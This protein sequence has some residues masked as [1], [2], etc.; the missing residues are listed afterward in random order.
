MA[1]LAYV[2]FMFASPPGFAI[3]TLSES[4]KSNDSVEML[5]IPG[6][7]LHYRE[8]DRAAL[9]QWKYLDRETT[10]TGFWI[11]RTEVTVEQ[12]FRC[13]N[14][15]ACQPTP[16]TTDQ[17]L[18]GQTLAPPDPE[19]GKCE[20]CL[21]YTVEPKSFRLCNAAANRLKYPVNCVSFS[22]AESY[23]N[24]AGKRLPTEREWERAARS[25]DHRLYP[26]GNAPP[27][28]QLCWT[29]RRSKGPIT[30]PVGIHPEGASP[31]AVLD[32]A[33]NVAE[34][35]STRN[36]DGWIYKGGGF[37]DYQFQIYEDNRVVQES[38]PMLDVGFRCARDVKAEVQVESMS[39]TVKET[40]AKSTTEK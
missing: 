9:P 23:C 1:T 2:S 6:G 20:T 7:Q 32:M 24:W 37:F 28:G 33:G 22:D 11:D 18:G 19:P 30:C 3:E 29:K 14:A 31:F 13:V 26:W 8:L 15:R 25:D 34:W 38:Q 27:K 5:F 35:T 39:P 36:G 17:T 4:A 16:R 12:Y 40:H 21:W 10:V